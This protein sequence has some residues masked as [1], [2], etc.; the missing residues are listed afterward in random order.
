MTVRLQSQPAPDISHFVSSEEQAAIARKLLRTQ[1]ISDS[2]LSDT[3]CH[4]HIS[5]TTFPADGTTSVCSGLE[6]AVV[7]TLQ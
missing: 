5:D 1:C 2:L 4:C 6:Q 3:H 7:H